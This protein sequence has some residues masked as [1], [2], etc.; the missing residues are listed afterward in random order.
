MT[1]IRELIASNGHRLV[2]CDECELGHRYVRPFDYSVMYGGTYDAFKF[3]ND[4]VV[5]VGATQ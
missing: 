4:Y 2:R 1:G 3:Y 5:D